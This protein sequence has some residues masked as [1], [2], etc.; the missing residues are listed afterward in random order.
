MVTRH[1]APPMA[2]A[3]STIFRASTST[4]CNSLAVAAP[5]HFSAGVSL[6]GSAHDRQGRSGAR[7]NLGQAANTGF[8]A[9]E[10]RAR[11]SA[12]LVDV[13]RKLYFR[14]PRVITYLR[15]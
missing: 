10:K 7:V 2:A 1:P 15:G 13:A 3:Q 8:L 4:S 5:I 14:M 11:R 12:G 6:D 9:V